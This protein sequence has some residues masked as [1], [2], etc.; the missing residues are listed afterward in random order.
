METAVR[1]GD[2]KEFH[3][4]QEVK[5]FQMLNAQRVDAVLTNYF[6]GA[7]QIK[8]LGYTNVVPLFPPLDSSPAFLTFSK[9]AGLEDLVTLFDSVLYEILI[10][11]TYQRIFD[12]YTKV[13][14]SSDAE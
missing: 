4:E 10:D 14:S 5:S 9:R 13:T 11:G 8:Q 3:V 1:R 7:Y 6:V 12:R 2:V